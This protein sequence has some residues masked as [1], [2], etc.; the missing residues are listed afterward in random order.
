MWVESISTFHAEERKIQLPYVND[1]IQGLVSPCWEHAHDQVP[2]SLCSDLVSAIENKEEEIVQDCAA[3][4]KR[5]K[6]FS[7]LT[8]RRTNT[9]TTRQ[10]KLHTI[11][12]RFL[13]SIQ[14]WKRLVQFRG[15]GKLGKRVVA[16]F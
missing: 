8:S 15:D 13:Q 14:N 9:I 11:T 6:D 10:R 5:Q 12:F 3:S 16:P 2:Y 1:P 4:Q 7:H